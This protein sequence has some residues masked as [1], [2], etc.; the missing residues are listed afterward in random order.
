MVAQFKFEWAAFVPLN[1]APSL[2]VPESQIRQSDLI[3]IVLR[4]DAAAPARLTIPDVLDRKD[5][6]IGFV[7]PRQRTDQQW[8]DLGQVLG[9]LNGRSL[10]WFGVSDVAISAAMTLQSNV[11]SVERSDLKDENV[12]VELLVPN[13]HVSL[14]GDREELAVAGKAR[15]SVDNQSVP[16]VARPGA[17]DF[18]IVLSPSEAGAIRFSFDADDHA[19]DVLQAH[20]RYFAKGPFDPIGQV[21]VLDSVV[22]RLLAP[23]E[24]APVRFDGEMVP[25]RVDANGRAS[26]GRVK[27]VFESRKPIRSHLQ[28]DNGEHVSLVPR[29]AACLVSV[30]APTSFVNNRVDGNAWYFTPLGSFDVEAPP[31]GSNPATP[32]L[33]RILIGNA[34]TEFIELDRAGRNA[35]DFALGGSFVEVP[36]WAVADGE[37]A[38]AGELEVNA[39][40]AVEDLTSTAWMK[41]SSARP[42]RY[43]TQS[44]RAPLYAPPEVNKA[45]EADPVAKADQ[46]LLPYLP[47]RVRDLPSDL[48]LPIVPIAGTRIEDPQQ[49]L[50]A[51][52][53]LAL[54]RLDKILDLKA[55]VTAAQAATTPQGF[56]A[57]LKDGRWSHAQISTTIH[58]SKDATAGGSIRKDSVPFSITLGPNSALGE[59]F[60]HPDLLLA[61]G[62]WGQDSVPKGS[63]AAEQWKFDSDV[64]T[65]R[66]GGVVVFKFHSGL[67]VD[68][69]ADP[70]TY[71][72][73]FNSDV[74]AAR[75]VVEEV[76][77]P[78]KT[79][80]TVQPS[81]PYYVPL[82]EILYDPHWTGVVF[83]KPSIATPPPELAGLIAEMPASLRAKY[84]AIPINRVEPGG[85]GFGQKSGAV[86]GLIFEETD[87]DPEVEPNGFYGSRVQALK[88]L[89]AGNTV[90]RFECKVAVKANQWFFEPATDG[91]KNIV[92]FEG[93]YEAHGPNGGPT[94]TFASITSFDF[95]IPSS[96]IEHVTFSRLTFVTESIGKRSDGQPGTSVRSR[97]SLRGELKFRELPGVKPLSDL[98]SFDG[99]SFEKL[100]LEVETSL[101]PGATSG[102]TPHFK[103]VAEGMVLDATAKPRA[104]SFLSSLP[105]KLKGLLC[106]L[107]NPASG[108]KEDI[109]GPRGFFPIDL[110]VKVDFPHFALVFGFDLG[111]FGALESLRGLQIDIALGWSGTL[112]VLALRLPE[113]TGGE[114][115]FGIEGV[116]KILAKDFYFK[117]SQG[118]DKKIVLVLRRAQLE[119]L[120]RRFPPDGNRVS[121][122]GMLIADP[123][124]G[125]AAWLATGEWPSGDSSDFIALGQKVSFTP[126]ATSTK[127]VITELATLF[128]PWHF[129]GEPTDALPT[130]VDTFLSA[131]G[132]LHY[133]QEHNWLIGLRFIINAFATGELDLILDDPTLYGIH[134]KYAGIDLLD[135]QYRRVSDGV[136]MFYIETPLPFPSFTAG[137][138]EIS[139]PHLGLS[140]LTD[141][142]FR[143]DLGFPVAMD[144]ERGFHMEMPPFSGAGGFYFARYATVG[145]DLLPFP[146]KYV[147]V[148][149]AGIGFKV[150]YGASLSFGPFKASAS[151][152]IYA[153]LEGAIGYPK[154]NIFQPDIAVRGRLGIIAS[155]GCHLDL[156]LTSIDFRLDIWVGIEVVVRIVDGSLRPVPVTI[157]V[158]VRVSVR[159][160]IARFSVFGATIEI[161][162]TLHFEKTFR[163]TTTL[164]GGNSKQKIAA[165]SDKVLTAANWAT[166]IL[167]PTGKQPLTIHFVPDVLIGAGNA[168]IAMALF[169]VEHSPIQSQNRDTPATTKT[170]FDRLARELV[171]WMAR[172]DRGAAGPFKYTKDELTSLAERLGTAHSEEIAGLTYATILEFLKVNFNV[173]IEFGKR[174][175]ALT[176]LPAFAELQMAIDAGPPVR[177]DRSVYTAA[178]LEKLERTLQ[179]GSEREQS[180]EAPAAV[181]APVPIAT[182]VMQEYIRSLIKIV[183]QDLADVATTTPT[184]ID[185]LVTA[186]RKGRDSFALLATTASSHLVHGLRVPG[187]A[188]TIG[189]PV[190]A[191][192]YTRIGQ[193]AK[194]FDTVPSTFPGAKTIALSSRADGSW[195][196]APVSLND[197]IDVN[198]FARLADLDKAVRDPRNRPPLP[199]RVASPV[200]ARRRTSSL[201]TA[202]PVV[203]QQLGIFRIPAELRPL[204]DQQ[205][206]LQ[207]VFATVNE[208][209]IEE[210]AAGEGAPTRVNS[211]WA[212]RA[213]FQVRKRPSKLAAGPA[214]IELLGTDDVTRRVLEDYLRR[215]KAED[216]GELTL[217]LNQPGIGT[218]PRPLEPIRND[219][220]NPILIVMTSLARRGNPQAKAPDADPPVDIDTTIP[221]AG[222]DHPD[223]FIGLLRR[224]SI[225]RDGGFTLALP[226]PQDQLSWDDNDRATLTLLVTLK[227]VPIAFRYANAVAI[228]P[229]DA[230]QK[231]G[232]S[233]A[234]SGN[235]EFT[236]SPRGAAIVKDS[237]GIAKS[238]LAKPGLMALELL[239]ANPDPDGTKTDVKTYLQLSYRLLSVT[240]AGDQSESALF[241]RPASPRE[242]TELRKPKDPSVFEEAIVVPEGDLKEHDWRYRHVIDLTTLVKN[243]TKPYDLVGTQLTV[244]FGWRDGFGNEAPGWSGTQAIPVLYQDPLIA[245]GN[246]PRVSISWAPSAK[247]DGPLL[248]T[249]GY[250]PR[251]SPADV[252]AADR[253]RRNGETL[254]DT[255]KRLN[256][257]PVSISD[258]EKDSWQRIEAQ[259]K[260]PGVSVFVSTSL[261]GGETAIPAAALKKLQDFVSKIAATPTAAPDDVLFEVPMKDAPAD[262][263]SRIRIRVDVA[264]RRSKNVDPDV[265]K[266]VPEVG[267]VSNV[268]RPGIDDKRETLQKFGAAFNAAYGVRYRLALGDPEDQN[269]GLG[270]FPAH[271]DPKLRIPRG[272]VVAAASIVSPKY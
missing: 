181:P 268:I 78:A 261:S 197:Q 233:L 76:I 33:I 22:Y 160:V 41:F 253:G 195:P 14:S 149:Q 206:P 39:K 12:S 28:T 170:D 242:L 256:P 74:A 150:G 106:R 40:T 56:V 45:N 220:Q 92:V 225:V 89:F 231:R 187:P 1:A 8:L 137:P 120:G 7:Q 217:Y 114:H 224:A 223:G 90:A 11:N 132:Q 169:G 227:S 84:L 29:D 97:V 243:K 37:F 272:Q 222:L 46:S 189:D 109:W 119:V 32:S 51:S 190:D 174:V 100:A 156:I 112:P 67:L 35:I 142:G 235:V 218:V 245:M 155:L 139:L 249:L 25:T 232:Y 208:A 153:M 117:M 103:F 122:G 19:L 178:D 154:T 4:F 107:T 30:R 110:P 250:R 13:A 266:Q 176:L 255:L 10:G 144:F 191:S 168:A 215:P 133:S 236:S 179:A 105:L 129:S 163:Y 38:K 54:T 102:G 216:A 238:S 116:L 166:T 52:N 31:T 188:V 118:P 185:D 121:V 221:A 234:F 134:V 130:A 248:V 49:R 86:S 16:L 71:K 148:L 267:A 252:L 159:W 113:I 161:A 162:I 9:R 77:A 36:P 263:D 203:G 68:I 128:N 199:V 81:S 21:H 93:H 270:T 201:G 44:E 145:S 228:S 101:P 136:G 265:V 204:I 61:L 257:A 239:R 246:W 135:L 65:D 260:D 115:G 177:F 251:L 271:W 104:S 143:I 2:Y 165:S 23:D 87:L 183:A 59:E 241:R 198:G 27:L 66:V 175:R 194:L 226:I 200:L 259:I 157:E 237:L 85:T 202:S 229:F 3:Q 209:D 141:G 55:P 108:A 53:R 182:V 219:T 126:S 48:L 73:A 262:P 80:E 180:K 158:G 63:L 152:S 125:Q 82:H 58:L 269:T 111:S 244:T 6:R 123:T 98:F 173:S 91:K 230:A 69:L 164:G 26:V 20:C 18:L 127:D 172:A 88:V 79:G 184:E 212:I 211:A 264:L 47:H 43:H 196:F 192:V 210:S 147:T 258:D 207:A 94:Y 186:L 124:H 95:R 213:D 140:I 247:V 138:M 57:T 96:I 17:P 70:A 50:L 131:T 64:A 5:L 240:I 151:I 146:G 24:G 167:S 171:L 214:I 42:V 60:L 34:G 99:L 72:K 75:A 205:L 83:F 254:N 15:L 62:Q 193:M